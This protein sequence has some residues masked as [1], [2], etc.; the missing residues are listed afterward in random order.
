MRGSCA[1]PFLALYSM[2]DTR[3]IFFYLIRALLTQNVCVPYG[4][5]HVTV[6]YVGHPGRNYID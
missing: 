1:V 3:I 6:T 5:N 2:R 4:L